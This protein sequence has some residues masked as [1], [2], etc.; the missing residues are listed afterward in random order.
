M[1]ALL[2]QAVRFRASSPEVSADHCN[3][4]HSGK[5]DLAPNASLRSCKGASLPVPRNI[6]LFWILI[7]KFATWNYRCT[8]LGIRLKVKASDRLCLISCRKIIE[9]SVSRIPSPSEGFFSHCQSLIALLYIHRCFFA[10]AISSN[11][12][13]PVKSQYAPSFLAGFR[14]ACAIV[15]AVKLQF[16]MFSAQISRFWVLW[17]HAFSASVSTFD[18]AF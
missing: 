9:S 11:P 7:V 4:S 10:H 1:T 3:Q 5:P 6:P 17:T 13:D 8:H 12:I 2:N 18:L 16:T 15:K 14:S